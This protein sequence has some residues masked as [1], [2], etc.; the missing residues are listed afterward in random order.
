MQLFMSSSLEFGFNEGLNIIS[1]KTTKFQFR[2]NELAKNSSHWMESN[3]LSRFEF[4][5][6]KNI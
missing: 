6:I 3:S 1:G 2:L 4:N 5:I